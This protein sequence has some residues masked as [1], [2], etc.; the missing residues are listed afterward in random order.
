MFLVSENV[1]ILVLI[2]APDSPAKDI[3]GKCVENNSV[4]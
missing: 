4:C 1:C 2:H 3:G